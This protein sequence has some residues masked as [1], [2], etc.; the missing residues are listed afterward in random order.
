MLQ[1]R[2]RIVPTPTQLSQD[3]NSFPLILNVLVTVLTIVVGIE[4]SFLEA[5]NGPVSESI[6]LLQDDDDMNVAGQCLAVFRDS[7][8]LHYSPRFSSI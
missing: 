1:V 7:Y 4:P 5:I 6:F 8:E 2:D 3:L